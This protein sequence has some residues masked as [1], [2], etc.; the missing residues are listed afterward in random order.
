[1]RLVPI[2]HAGATL[3]LFVHDDDYLSNQIA[4]T[5]SFYEAEILETVR[6]HF[7]SHRTVIDVGANIGNHSSF[8]LKYLQP[9]RLVC[10]EPV[11]ANFDVLQKNIE[12]HANGIPVEAH[13]MALGATTGMVEMIHDPR[14][15]GSCEV[16][17][18]RP[19]T[20]EMRTLDSFGYEDVSLLKIDVESSFRDVLMGSL[21]T[22]LVSHPIVLTEGPFEQVFPILGPL[23]YL[24]T[25][26]WYTDTRTYLYQAKP[27]GL[28]RV[29]GRSAVPPV[30]RRP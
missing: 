24:C 13:R 9:R 17:P 11:Q 5:G 20:I 3:D 1:M 16:V 23:G 21:R 8:F 14:N 6:T 4:Q 19:G 25:A 12:L 18:D 22:L 10:F 26:M 29:S 15:M 28:T 2:D 27:S 7:P 30:G